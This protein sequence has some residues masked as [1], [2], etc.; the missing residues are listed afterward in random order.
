MIN[1]N[2]IGW[3]LKGIQLLPAIIKAVQAVEHLV[4]EKGEPKMTAALELV[5][6]FVKSTEGFAGIDLA[7]TEIRNAVKEVIEAYVALQNVIK[8]KGKVRVYLKALQDAGQLV[9]VGW[10]GWLP[11]TAPGAQERA[12]KATARTE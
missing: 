9:K 11:A 3:T 7:D 12:E 5:D 1:A 4:K 10:S 2:I 6:I 8:R